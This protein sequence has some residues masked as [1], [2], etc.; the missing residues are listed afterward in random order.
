MTRWGSS[1]ASRAI[2]SPWPS[3]QVNLGAQPRAGSLA[4]PVAQCLVGDNNGITEKHGTNASHF[5]WTA[6]RHGLVG[7]RR[8][9]GDGSLGVARPQLGVAP[10]GLASPVLATLRCWRARQYPSVRTL[11]LLSPLRCASSYL[12]PSS[13]SHRLP[14]CSPLS[15]SGPLSQ[16]T[17]R[18][19]GALV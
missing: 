16:T 11:H 12:S 10:S 18:P 6:C 14:I 17:D 2:A 9:H 5:G 13:C 7:M 3:R 19:S 8:K 15:S 4:N 1:A